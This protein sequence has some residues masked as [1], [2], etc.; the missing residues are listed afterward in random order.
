MRAALR[1]AGIPRQLGLDQ[2]L[3]HAESIRAAVPPRPGLSSWFGSGRRDRE[4]LRRLDRDMWRHFPQLAERMVGLSRGARVP[5]RALLAALARELG[6][7]GTEVSTGLGG[8]CLAFAAGGG[9]EGPRLVKLL[10]RD[11]ADRGEPLLRESH[12]EGGIRSFDATRPWFAAALAGVNAEGLAITVSASASGP[13]DTES[14]WAPACLLV[15]DCLQRFAS[16][17]S[18]ADWCLKRPAGGRAEIL[19]ADARGGVLGVSLGPDGRRVREPDGGVL[20]GCD[21][22]PERQLIKKACQAPGSLDP[23]NLERTVAQLAEATPA[24]A[25]WLDPVGRRAG[26][27]HLAPESRDAEIGHSELRD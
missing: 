12:P 26:F 23:E 7:Q 19:V 17:E 27:S 13:N 9:G 18:A 25:V 20:V 5:R 8:L 10:R 4:L 21:R 24:L 11:R 3:A 15:Q 1:C 22:E 2:G 6:W 16:S 14:C